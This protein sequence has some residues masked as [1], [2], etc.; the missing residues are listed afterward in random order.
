MASPRAA[1]AHVRRLAASAGGSVASQAVTALGSLVLQLVAVRF[2]G[3]VALGAFALLS[4]ILV[5]ATTVYTSWVGDSLN[6]L[7][8]FDPALRSSL[9][10]SALFFA[11][12]GS[13]VGVALALVLRLMGPA[14]V[15]LFAVL[16][17]LW[18]AQETFRR[19]LHARLEFGALLANDL[20][21]VITTLVFLGGLRL[22]TGGFDLDGILLAMCVGCLAALA[23]TL[24]RLPR[25][26]Y[27]LV[28][29]RLAGMRELSAFAAWRS[30]QSSLRPLTLLVTR[31]AI[32]TFASR[33]VLA[34]VEAARLLMTPALT[35]I[36]GAGGYLLPTFVRQR[37]AGI[38][39]RP[40]NALV[41]SLVLAGVSCACGVAAIATLGFFGPLITGG[42]FTLDAVSV[43][44]WAVYAVSFSATLPLASMA[45]AYK[46]SRLVFLVRGAETAV[47]LAAVL[48]L[49][50][51]RPDLA[52]FAPYC[53]G[54][55]GMVSGLLLWWRLRIIRDR[56][57]ARHTD[58]E[59]GT[60]AI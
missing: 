29:P 59:R 26:E 38:P 2:I 55:G 47:G 13:A 24:R 9:V 20:T 48:I 1:M 12:V 43:G 33:T 32:D 15:A 8:R 42:A 19:V 44:G 54:L 17:T 57:R 10:A 40:R 11:T 6:V 4:A 46:Q 18:L 14:G 50:V 28:R 53:I 45:T 39:M 52:V 31:V 36:S 58:P 22:I 60:H 49:L 3:P 23:V 34:V 21:Y 5:T 27:A 25:Q 30:A 56:V 37:D 7:D 16:I 41:G 51:L 35:L